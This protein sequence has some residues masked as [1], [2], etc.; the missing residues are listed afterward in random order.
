MR[1]NSRDN[2][3]IAFLKSQRRPAKM[4]CTCKNCLYTFQSVAI[5]EQCPDCGKHWMV[6]EAT[7]EEKQWYARIQEENRHEES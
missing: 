6:R 7:D 3:Y 4:I 2:E 1:N 5:P